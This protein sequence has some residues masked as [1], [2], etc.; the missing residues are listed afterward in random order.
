MFVIGEYRCR[1]E[2]PSVL[3][4]VLRVVVWIGEIRQKVVVN[5]GLFYNSNNEVAARC[6]ITYVCVDKKTGRSEKIPEEV[7]REL[8]QE[9]Q[10][11]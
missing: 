3:D 7:R 10:R 6:E 4:D 8:E 5:R 11:D 9:L 1:I 2:K